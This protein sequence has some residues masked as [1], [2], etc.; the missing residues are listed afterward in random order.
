[1]KKSFIKE[2]KYIKEDNRYDASLIDSLYRN[3]ISLMTITM[4]LTP[5]FDAGATL[6]LFTTAMSLNIISNKM[7]I[8][9]LIYNRLEDKKDNNK[10]FRLIPKNH[11]YKADFA[12]YIREES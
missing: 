1:M 12:D 11:I 6:T 3:S 4:I 5:V 2:I 7:E 9:N 10:C 8:N